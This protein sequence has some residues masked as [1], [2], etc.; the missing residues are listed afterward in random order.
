[1]PVNARTASRP[2]AVAWIFP[3]RTDHSLFL[4]LGGGTACLGAVLGGGC[5]ALAG[6]RGRGRVGEGVV[7]VARRRRRLAGLVVA[8]SAGHGGLY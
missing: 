2:K 1:M 5:L 4:A 7:Q 3:E 8:G 6:D